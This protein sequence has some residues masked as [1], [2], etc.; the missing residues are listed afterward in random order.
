MCRIELRVVGFGTVIV[1]VSAI[2]D[3]GCESQRVYNM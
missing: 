3:C 1:D 2:C